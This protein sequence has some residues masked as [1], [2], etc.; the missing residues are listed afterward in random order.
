MLSTNCFS[1]YYLDVVFKIWQGRRQS[2]GD[3]VRGEGNQVESFHRG[4]RIDARLLF[5]GNSQ[6]EEVEGRSVKG[7]KS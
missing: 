5:L 4:L 7:V 6:L 3:N 1:T 2:F